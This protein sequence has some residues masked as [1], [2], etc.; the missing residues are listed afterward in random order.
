MTKNSHCISTANI[1]IASL[2][3]AT[4]MHGNVYLNHTISSHIKR[5]YISMLGE[6]AVE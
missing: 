3:F 1:Y 2:L 6:F 5:D 4:P